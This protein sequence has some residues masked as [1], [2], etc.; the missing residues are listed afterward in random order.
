MN[1]GENI[2]SKNNYYTYI[3]IVFIIMTNEGVKI[4]FIIIVVFVLSMMAYIAA[5]YLI[6]PIIN[7]II[8][9]W[10]GLPIEESAIPRD[11]PLRYGGSSKP[12]NVLLVDVANMYVGWFMEK[13]RCRRLPYMNQ[14]EL[15]ASYVDCMRDHHRAFSKKNKSAMVNYIIKNYK[16]G[17]HKGVMDAPKISD[18]A[19]DKLH[20]F[21]DSTRATIIVAEDYSK[22]SP[23]K[24]KNS[25]LHYLRGRDDYLLFRM[26]RYY[27]KKFT[28]AVIMSDDNFKDFTN[29]G[30]VPPFVASVV[31][32][33]QDRVYESITPRPND[34]GQLKDYKMVKITL[35]FSFDDPKFVKSST[36]KIPLPGEVWTSPR[37]RDGR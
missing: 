5:R 29:F 13:N 15:L 33:D 11:P 26:A 4:L 31:S 22:H 32:P 8:K 30:F 35:E 9:L 2:F 37:V 14:D 20:S 1:F 18:A 17:G 27:K 21:V 24:W 6:L 36:Y 3:D 7:E 25:R 16:Y 23:H 12:K 28:N 19:W 34:L 10:K